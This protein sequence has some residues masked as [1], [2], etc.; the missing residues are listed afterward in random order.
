M[1]DKQPDWE[2]VL[3]HLKPK[4]VS[5]CPHAP[6]PKQ[7]AFLKTEVLEALFGGAAGGGKSDALLMSALQYVDVPGY[8]AMIFRNTFA[9]L[10]LPG[11]IM[12]RLREWLG[13]YPE[14]KWSKQSNMAVF[15]SGARITFGYLDGP[16]DHLRYKG[17]EAQF[18][19]FD[20]L[21]EIREQHYRYLISRLRKPNHGPLSRV[22]LRARAATNPAPNWVRRYFIEEGMEKKRL[23]VPCKFD[24]NPFV[25]SESYSEALD[26]LSAVD[27]ARLK[28]GDWYAEE[29][30]NLFDRSDFR[31]ISPEDVPEEAFMNVVRY[32]DL[33]GSEPTDANPDPDYT[34]GAKV[35]IVDGVM[36]V[37]DVRRFRTG[38][39]EIESRIWQTAQE[40]GANVQIRMEKDPGQAGKAQISHFA[41]NVL[42]GFNFDGNPITNDKAS[43]VANWASKAKRGEIHLVRGDWVTAFLDEAMAFDPMAGKNSKVHDDQ[44]DA[45][46]GAFEILTGIKGKTR[47]R[48]QIIL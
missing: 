2:K 21:T 3:E 38:P 26:R 45:I 6:H 28:G 12:D 37:L 24:E 41:R 14:V 20:E 8:S 18:L 33:A 40:D 22:P 46:S 17:A 11:A 4:E 13:E 43:R 32:W 7:T 47:K 48:V 27:K 42:L 9:D 36:Y 44:M 31:V 16:D 23:Y 39:A 10:A 29:S 34:V 25:D 1:V 15:P 30:G 19:G 5:Y 35:A